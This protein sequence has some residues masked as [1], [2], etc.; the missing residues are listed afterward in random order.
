MC[1]ITWDHIACHTT[2]VSLAQCV[3]AHELDGNTKNSAGSRVSLHTHK[4]KDEAHKEETAACFVCAYLAMLV[5]LNT[6]NYST[7]KSPSYYGII[8]HR[9]PPAQTNTTKAVLARVKREL[10]SILRFLLTRFVHFCLTDVLK[11]QENAYI[12]AKGIIFSFSLECICYIHNKSHQIII[13]KQETSSTSLDYG[14]LSV[15]TSI[16]ITAVRAS[17]F[18]SVLAILH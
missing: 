7:S 6:E 14:I 9:G 10:T 2:P 4:P 17:A 12:S 15:H 5:Q 1:S 3:C 8:L 18:F 13:R 16:F 11:C